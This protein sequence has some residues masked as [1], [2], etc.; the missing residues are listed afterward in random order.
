[1][2][3]ID[4]EEYEQYG[5]EEKKP[6]FDLNEYCEVVSPPR[7]VLEPYSTPKTPRNDTS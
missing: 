5:H 2:K 4:L 1:M 3:K 6:L 7:R